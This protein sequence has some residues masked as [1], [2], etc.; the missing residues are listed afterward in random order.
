MVTYLVYLF[1]FARVIFTHVFSRILC[2][3]FFFPRFLHFLLQYV[4]LGRISE[5]KRAKRLGNVISNERD[6]S[7][8]L[9]TKKLFF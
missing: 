9:E 2:L 7:V 4:D 6:F 1:S 5:K 8:S 3:L